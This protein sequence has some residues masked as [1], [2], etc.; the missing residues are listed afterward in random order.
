MLDP[1][2]KTESRAKH[3]SKQII[4]IGKRLEMERIRLGFKHVEIASILNCHFNTY[5]NYE[6]GKR[7]MPSTLMIKLGE[8]G[9]DVFFVLTGQQQSGMT[10]SNNKEPS[11][12]LFNLEAISIDEDSVFDNLLVKC[13]S[14]EKTLL[15]VGAKPYDDYT[16]VQLMNIASTQ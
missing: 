14:I 5:R 13:A 8:S 11:P 12:Y 1:I 10:I 16:Y 7:D 2:I 6:A 15:S 9:F 3:F 4:E